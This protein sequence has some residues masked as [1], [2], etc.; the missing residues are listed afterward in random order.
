MSASGRS[1]GGVRSV[2]ADQ[3]VASSASVARIA[4]DAV[5]ASAAA[6]AAAAAVTIVSALAKAS[7]SVVA[8]A[9]AAQLL[10]VAE[11]CSHLPSYSSGQQRAA[12]ATHQ[13]LH[14]ALQQ[15]LSASRTN[16]LFC[17]CTSLS[18]SLADHPDVD[19]AGSFLVR[20]ECRAGD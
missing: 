7:Q 20:R 13:G 19:G 2:A 12:F 4:V 17:F 18:T 8:V 1:A 10:T 9:V 16:S 11:A 15:F 6:F 3:T 14:Q 5:A